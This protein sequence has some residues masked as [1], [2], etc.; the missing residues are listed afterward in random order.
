MIR[1]NRT[2]D[3]QAIYGMVDL[4]REVY[5][6]IVTDELSMKKLCAK[7]VPKMLLAEQKKKNFERT[8]ALTFYNALRTNR[9]C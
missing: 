1:K 8:Y 2:L 4:E 9:V 5:Q 7:M 6:A 3:D